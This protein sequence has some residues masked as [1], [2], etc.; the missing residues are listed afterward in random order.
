MALED[1][2]E[3]QKEVPVVSLAFALIVVLTLVVMGY[4]VGRTT[5]KQ[6]A[7]DEFFKA[8]LSGLRADMNRE[9][10]LLIEK[11]ESNNTRIDRKI[12]NHEN[13]YHKVRK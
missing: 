8:E 5:A 6:E 9:V 13:E 10:E 2:K 1:T 11:V 3:M 7:Q 4:Y 12:N